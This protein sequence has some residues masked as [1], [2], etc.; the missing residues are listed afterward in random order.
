M[1]MQQSEF[2]RTI[3]RIVPVSGPFTAERGR[4]PKAAAAASIASPLNIQPLLR[5][6]TTESG[7]EGPPNRHEKAVA[8]AFAEIGETGAP[9]QLATADHP[10]T[11]DQQ[12]IEHRLFLLTQPIHEGVGVSI[13]ESRT[14]RGHVDDGTRA[15]FR[16]GEVR[17]NAL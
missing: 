9:S 8:P 7:P 13:R 1:H 15:T 16:R 10:S 6:V 3:A 11:I 4:R 5:T 2:W 12:D 17:V 14:S